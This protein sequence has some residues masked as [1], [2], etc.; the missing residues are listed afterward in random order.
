MERS[1]LSTSYEQYAEI[2]SE[3]VEKESR[4]SQLKR[5]SKDLEESLAAYPSCATS[6][7]AHA[8]TNIAER[9]A[10]L[11]SENAL[12][13]TDVFNKNN[14]GDSLIWPSQMKVFV[15]KLISHSFA[16]G[17]AVEKPSKNGGG[18]EYH[19]NIEL[20]KWSNPDKALIFTAIVEGGV[21]KTGYFNWVNK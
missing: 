10:T 13:Y 15:I 20:K 19:Y 6:L 18:K 11:A 16:K 9:L 17:E 14:P 5:L 21:V 4:I 3:I 1:N 12:I 8:S 2:S 7:S